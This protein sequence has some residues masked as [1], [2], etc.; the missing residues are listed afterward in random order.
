MMTITNEVTDL[1]TYKYIGSAD[2][3]R[4]MNNPLRRCQVGWLN[5]LPILRIDVPN[6]LNMLI[7]QYLV[8]FIQICPQ[9]K[10]AR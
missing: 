2:L 5:R 6:R 3:K 7:I 8:F 4:T 10:G 1:F 9:R